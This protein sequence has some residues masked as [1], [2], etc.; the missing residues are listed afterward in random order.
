MPCN[1][2]HYKQRLCNGGSLSHRNCRLRFYA[3]NVTTGCAA[4]R[5]S[6]VEPFID[7]FADKTSEDMPYFTPG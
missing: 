1:S 3:I 5:M 2:R 6:E 4:Y 7:I